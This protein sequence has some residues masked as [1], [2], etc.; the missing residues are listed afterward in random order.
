MIN[1]D[2]VNNTHDN[3]KKNLPISSMSQKPTRVHHLIFDT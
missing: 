3:N 1:E 2:R